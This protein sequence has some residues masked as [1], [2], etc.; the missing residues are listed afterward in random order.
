MTEEKIAR[1]QRRCEREKTARLEAESLLE[2]KSLELF[3]ANQELKGLAEGLEEQ[4]RVRTEEMEAARDQ[5][6][7][8]AKSKSHFLAN[9]SHEIRTPMNGMLGMFRMLHKTQLT[10]R[11]ERL[12]ETAEHSAEMLVQIINDVL[13]FSKLEANKITLEALAFDPRELMEQATVSFGSDG[14]N[15]DV[16]IICDVAVDMPSVLQGDPTRIQQVLNNF[17]SNA[18]KFTK[19]GEVVASAEFKQGVL[20]IRVRDT[21]VGMTAEQQGKIF[22]AFAQADE[23]TTRKFGG[24]GLGLAICKNLTEMMGGEIGVDSEAGKGSCFYIRLPLEVIEDSPSYSLLDESISTKKVLLAIKNDCLARQLEALFQAWRFTNFTVI[25]DAQ[26]LTPDAIR[27]DL[28]IAD[29]A[30]PHADSLVE[31]FV[32]IGS[33][34]IKLTSISDCQAPENGVEAV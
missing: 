3:N 11:Q 14:L 13:D 10:D 18:V 26:Q 5:A 12:L 15:G 4:V 22:K 21:G 32:E 28:L 16:E 20:D 8:S 9:M 27:S 6:L 24:T 25:Q 7:A 23:S 31:S 2:S 19:E 34:V 29:M 33:K 1:L 17:L 30:L